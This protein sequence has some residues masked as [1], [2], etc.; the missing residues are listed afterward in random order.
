MIGIDQRCLSPSRPLEGQ[1]RAAAE[2]GHA[3]VVARPAVGAPAARWYREARIATWAL[4][5]VEP[6]AG[7]VTPE[8][9]EADLE[10]AALAMR[11][12]APLLLV[13]PGELP[14]AA[15]P[16]PGDLRAPTA[17]RERLLLQLCRHLHRLLGAFPE[18]TLA[19]RPMASERALLGA[20]ELRLVLEDLPGPRLGYWA[21][22]DIAL[23]WTR[24]GADPLA[25]LDAD[26][27]RLLGVDLSD[28]LG[29]ELGLPPGAGEVDWAAVAGQLGPSERRVLSTAQP[30]SSE[31]LRAASAFLDQNGIR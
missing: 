9:L 30:L 20:E 13:T 12:G 31:A 28:A 17:S 10:R 4:A 16:Q 26:R 8:G 19:L 11:L 1:L 14:P 29:P 21:A 5:E 6:P 15:A 23:R 18:L 24:Q 27:G 2:L 25:W 22:T 7:L 3:A